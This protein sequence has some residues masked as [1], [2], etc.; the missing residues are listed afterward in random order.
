MT[1]AILLTGAS[2]MLGSRAALAL[3][4]AGHTVVGADIAP[5]K[6]EHPNYRHVVCDLTR[7]DAAAALFRESRTL[8]PPR[9]V[10]PA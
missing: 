10:P 1:H 8:S 7:P 6:V 3:C 4:E 2:G 9:F 5:A